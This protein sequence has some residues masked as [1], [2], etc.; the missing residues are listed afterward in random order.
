MQSLLMLVFTNTHNYCPTV[1]P[2]NLNHNRE[3]FELHEIVTL[4]EMQPPV[5][6]TLSRL[7]KP[8][9]IPPQIMAHIGLQRKPKYYEMHS[10]ESEAVREQLP[11][12]RLGLK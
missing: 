5:F 7:S 6:V 2:K 8:I 10:N 1:K 11:H 4:F 12:E 9:T 3:I